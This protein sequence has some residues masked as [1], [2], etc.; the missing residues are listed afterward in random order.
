M[1]KQFWSEGFK[2]RDSL[3]HIGVSV[4]VILE[5]ILRRQDV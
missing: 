1:H 2:G 5:R 4:R 3:R